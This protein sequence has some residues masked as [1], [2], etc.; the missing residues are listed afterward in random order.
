M[1]AAAQPISA[2]LRSTAGKGAARRLRAE[3]SIP[4]VAYG[5]A[6]E[7]RALTV[8][9]KEIL[10]VLKSQRGQNTLLQLKLE[11]S[12]DFL[13]LIKDYSYHPVTRKLQHVDF[14]EV[15]LEQKVTVEV[16][17]ITTGKAVGV[18]QGG[19]LHQVF[20]TLRISA[21]PD[22]IPLAIELDITALGLNQAAATQDLKLPEGVS[23]LLAP[24][25]TIINITAPEKDRN[26]EANAEKD[27][28][29]TKKK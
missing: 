25:Q 6:I 22:K 9:P 8:S 5:K 20:R 2:S 10:T 26:E 1:T 13:A 21:N 12:N 18:T 24:E 16:P 19:V 14:I 17:L 29:D 15:K 7:P 28:K 3:G 4:A 23:V 11:G 27:A